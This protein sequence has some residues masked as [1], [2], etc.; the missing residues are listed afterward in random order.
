MRIT[1]TSRDPLLGAL[2]LRAMKQIWLHGPRTVKQVH[3]AMNAE[4]GAVPLMYVTILTVMRHLVKRKILKQNRRIKH[5]PGAGPRGHTF[6][7]MATPAEYKHL[8]ATWFLHHYFDDDLP[9]FEFALTPI[10][11]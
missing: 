4:P 6:I 5:C 3:E 7:P 2:Q 10:S 11:N 9:A 8:V 1:K